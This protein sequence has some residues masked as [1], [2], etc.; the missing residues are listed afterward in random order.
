MPA[1]RTILAEA[2]KHNPDS[3]Q[4]WLAAFKLE[5]KNNEPERARALL[6]KAREKSD[7][8]RVWMKSAVLE[9]EQQNEQVGTPSAREWHTPNGEQREI[10]ERRSLFVGW[11]VVCLWHCNNWLLVACLGD[12]C[13]KRCGW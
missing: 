10:W 7:T 13:R 9:R 6:Q 1:A 11:V 8:A 4:I 5:N 3:E 2:N 12:V